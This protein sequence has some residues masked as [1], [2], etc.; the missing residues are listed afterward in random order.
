[1]DNTIQKRYRFNLDL[2]DPTQKALNDFL[3]VLDS[4]T[5][6]ERG[7]WLTRALSFYHDAVLSGAVSSNGNS[8]AHLNLMA[9]TLAFKNGYTPE[10]PIGESGSALVQALSQA[11]STQSLTE[12]TRQPTQQSPAPVESA[13]N[14]HE[15]PAEP[16]PEPETAPEPAPASNTPMKSRLSAMM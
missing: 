15:S 9:Q 2:A 13:N 3:G 12:P 8:E 10:N 7:A 16:R 1:M 14:H 6:K 4:M 5:I 11:A